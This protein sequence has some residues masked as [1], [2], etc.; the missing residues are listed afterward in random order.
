MRPGETSFSTGRVGTL[1]EGSPSALTAPASLYLYCPLMG[2]SSRSHVG[3]DSLSV[4]LLEIGNHQSRAGERGV[5]AFVRQEPTDITG[6]LLSL[7][8]SGGT[9]RKAWMN[10]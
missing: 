1:Q 7:S 4:Y 3:S 10:P 9:R 8:S 5:W 6:L 2:R